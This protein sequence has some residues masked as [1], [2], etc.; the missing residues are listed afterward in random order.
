MN[1]R[2]AG[3]VW[4][5]TVADRADDI[6]WEEQAVE[7]TTHVPRPVQADTWAG[8]ALHQITPG[9]LS[10]LVLIF[11]AVVPRSVI[12]S[13]PVLSPFRL[14]TG[15]PDPGCG[16][17]RSLVALAHGD[18]MDSLYFHPLGIMVAALFATLMLV[19]LNPWR[20]GLPAAHPRL[21]PLRSSWALLEW[22]MLGPTPWVGIAAFAVVWLVRLPLFLAGI[23]IF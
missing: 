6:N 16:M 20:S 17:T 10:L 2:P 14:A 22:L 4:Q 21:A 13:G 3:G 15:L 8:R 18:L 7:L 23:W 19:D 11:A 5:Y 1:G 12:E 9:R